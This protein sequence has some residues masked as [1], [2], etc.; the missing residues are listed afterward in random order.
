[1]PR[2]LTADEA[3]ALEALRRQ[4]QAQLELRRNLIEL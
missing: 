4:T 1:V 3:K 2:N